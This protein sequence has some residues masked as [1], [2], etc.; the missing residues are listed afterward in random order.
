MV[1]WLC[2]EQYS[3]EPTRAV[4]RFQKVYLGK[5]DSEI[6]P[7]LL[8]RGY[9]ALMRME[10]HLERRQWLVDDFSAADLCLL[11]YTALAPEG[12]FDLA[13]FPAVSDWISRA[14]DELH[15]QFEG[16]QQ[17]RSEE[18]TSELQSLMRISYAVFC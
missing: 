2:C 12:G 14:S 4:R 13:Q 15:V 3:H 7:T 18:H 17:R 8:E 10:N 9:A 5:A 16:D 1:E 6:D 11:P